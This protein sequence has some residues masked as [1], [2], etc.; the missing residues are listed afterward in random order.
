MY[1]TPKARNHKYPVRIYWI[2]S[3]LKYRNAK[4]IYRWHPT[5]EQQVRAVMMEL[6]RFFT[7]ECLNK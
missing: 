1:E 7:K 4:F 3:E 2:P 6:G 5:K